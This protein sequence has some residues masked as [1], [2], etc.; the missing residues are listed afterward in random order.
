[1]MKKWFHFKDLIQD[2]WF[3]SYFCR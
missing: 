2:R 3:I 1:M